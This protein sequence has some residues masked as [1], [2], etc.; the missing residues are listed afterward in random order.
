MNI[1]VSLY[2]LTRYMQRS[3]RRYVQG[4]GLGLGLGL[5]LIY[6]DTKVNVMHFV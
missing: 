1:I 2:A 5:T 6:M 3:I 4:L